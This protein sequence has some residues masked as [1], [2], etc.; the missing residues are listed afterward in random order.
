MKQDRLYFLDGLKGLAAIWVVL[1]HFYLLVFPIIPSGGRSI[2]KIP[3]VN[4]F[5]NGNLAVH[6]FLIISAYVMTMIIRKSCNMLSLQNIVVKRY[7]RLMIPISIIVFFTCIL[8]YCNL[9][10]IHEF[11]EITGNVKIVDYFDNLRPVDFVYTLLFSPLGHSTVIGPLWMLKYIFLGT[12]VIVILS[13][14]L[15]NLG[16][17]RKI[18]VYTIAFLL[19]YYFSWNFVSVI[20]GMIL[21]EL[22]I[23]E[24]LCFMNK[25]ITTVLLLFAVTIPALSPSVFHNIVPLNILSAVCLFLAVFYSKFLKRALSSKAFLFLG[26]ISLGVYLIHWPIYCTFSCHLM[27]KSGFSLLYVMLSLLSSLVIILALSFLYTKYVE[28]KSVYIVNKITKSLVPKSLA[29]TSENRNYD[30]PAYDVS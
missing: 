21:Y 26:K 9:T 24:F 29:D 15:Q 18:V 20:V 1:H 19:A 17:A 12:F 7:F 27:L 16:G 23:G 11:S 10:T 28:S 2:E 6:L 22:C 3:F 13:I 30:S 4:V 8:Y 14:A 25:W 5:I